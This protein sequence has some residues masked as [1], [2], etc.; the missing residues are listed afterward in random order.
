MLFFVFFLRLFEL[1]DG[2]EILICSKPHLLAKLPL[3]HLTRLTKKKKK[4]SSERQSA[5][6]DLG[7]ISRLWECSGHTGRPGVCRVNKLK[8]PL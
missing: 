1:I 6:M 5:K 3:E 7:P 2:R 8:C 4:K